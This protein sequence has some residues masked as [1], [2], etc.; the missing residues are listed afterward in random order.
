MSAYINLETNEY[1]LHEGDIRLLY[2][3]MGD[4]FILPEGFAEVKESNP[5]EHPVTKKARETAPLLTDEGYIRQWEFIDMTPQEIE[6]YNEFLTDDRK[7]SL[8]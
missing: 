4:T 2:P 7:I 3:D 8:P 1:P 5:P 6:R